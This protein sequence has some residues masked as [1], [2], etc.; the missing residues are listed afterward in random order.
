MIMSIN[1]ERMVVQTMRDEIQSIQQQEFCIMMSSKV[2]I[3]FPTFPA[4]KQKDKLDH[5]KRKN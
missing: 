4:V 1:I 3:S 2:M 5:I